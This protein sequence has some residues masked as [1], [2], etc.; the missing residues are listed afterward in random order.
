[1]A[2]VLFTCNP[3]APAKSLF[4]SAHVVTFPK[5][6]EPYTY[7]TSTYLSMVFARTGEAAGSVNSFIESDI[8]PQLLRDFATYDAFLLIVPPQFAHV[9]SMLRTKFDELFGPHLTGRIFTTE[10]VK[11]AKTVVESGSELVVSFG[12]KNEQYGLAKNRLNLPL[13]ERSDYGAMLAVSY[14]L[15]GQIQKAHPAYFKDNIVKY[16]EQASRLFNQPINPIV[17]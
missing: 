11:H 2:A 7:N 5:N 15:V 1:M 9:R 8:K 3:D 6:R 17:E 4:P 12:M 14:Y 10:E 16:T 13:P